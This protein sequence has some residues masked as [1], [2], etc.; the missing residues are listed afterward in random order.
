MKRKRLTD[1]QKIYLEYV[2]ASMKGFPTDV[3]LFVGKLL[4][5]HYATG[6]PKYIYLSDREITEDTGL[7][8]KQVKLSRT[9]LVVKKLIYW[10]KGTYGVASHYILL[11]DDNGEVKKLDN[12]LMEEVN[13]VFASKVKNNNYLE[14]KNEEKVGITYNLLQITSNIL[15]LTDN[16]KQIT[17]NSG[18]LLSSNM[19]QITGNS[20]QTTSNLEQINP[21]NNDNS[22][23]DNS[24]NVDD[25]FKFYLKHIE[26]VRR[27]SSTEELK[28]VREEIEEDRKEMKPNPNGYH[29]LLLED[30][31]KKRKEE[32]SN[33]TPIEEKEETYEEKTRRREELADRRLA[34]RV[35]KGSAFGEAMTG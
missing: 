14:A 3:K 24:G 11:F 5:V 32:L 34:D 10:V 4:Q 7:D 8:W 31:F 6:Q 22:T 2:P 21:N 17:S 13:N 28:R 23:T 9:L 30:I 19:E 26:D 15:P 16:S 27:A 25:G 18:T 35:A 1:S 33:Q 29:T 20:K 12:S